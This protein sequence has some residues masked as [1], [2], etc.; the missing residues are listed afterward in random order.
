MTV[1]IEPLVHAALRELTPVWNEDDRL[2]LSVPVS[3]PSGALVTLEVSAG[4]DLAMVTDR[5]FGRYEAEMYGAEGSFA[6]AA[7]RAA[8][9]AGVRFDGHAIFAM[10]VP[11]DR[12]A[13]GMVA[14]ANASTAAAAAAIRAESSRRTEV[15]NEII[16][17]RLHQAFPQAK[18]D[19]KLT[20]PGDRAEW[21]AHN[22]VRL[23]DR[24]AIFEPVSANTQSI[25]SKFTMFS[26][27]SK[28]PDLSLTA[29]V[30]NTSELQGK[31]LMLMDVARIIEA[32]APPDEYRELATAA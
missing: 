23:G 27:L 30:G 1:S 26:D 22:V 4:R 29:V 15:Q 6:S 31:G 17:A 28:R 7:K 9:A 10:K 13:G 20:L 2:C 24:M 5:G 3:Y 16:Q 19:R 18:I 14:V 25:A 21:E 8:A 11:L 32:G 12:L